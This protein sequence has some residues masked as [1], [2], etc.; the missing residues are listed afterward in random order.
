MITVSLNDEDWIEILRLIDEAGAAIS[1]EVCDDNDPT[2]LE[3][4]ALHKSI[5]QQLQC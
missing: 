3:Y 4:L 2:L 1:S 5:T